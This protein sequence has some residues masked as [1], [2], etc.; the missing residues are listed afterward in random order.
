MQNVEKSAKTISIVKVRVI[1]KD[2]IMVLEVIISE[3]WHDKTSKMTC[4]PSEESDQ[5]GRL[6]SL[7]RVITVCSMGSQGPSVYIQKVRTDQTGR[8]PKLILSHPWAHII[9]LVLSCCGSFVIKEF[10]SHMKTCLCYN[11]GQAVC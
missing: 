1:E 2:V 9:L 5:P 10:R 4:S 11:L 7:I 3:P 6:P 8:M